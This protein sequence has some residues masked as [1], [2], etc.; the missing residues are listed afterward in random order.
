M[1][2]Y[3]KILSFLLVFA[4]VLLCGCSTLQNEEQTT[5]TPKME[6]VGFVEMNIEPAYLQNAQS[7]CTKDDLLVFM[8]STYT[9]KDGNL[10]IPAGEEEFDD[11]DVNTYIVK[12]DLK[13]NKLVDIFDLKECPIKELWGV[14]LDNDKIVVFSDSEKKNAYYDL[15]M[16]FIEETDRIVFDELE[17]AK[18]SNFYTNMSAARNGFCDF[19]GTNNNQIVYF[20]DDPNTAYIFS[21]DKTYQPSEMSFNNGF[22][23]CETY[24]NSGE[25]ADFKVIDYKGAK[26]INGASIASKDYGYNNITTGQTGIGDK[27]V[28]CTEYLSNYEN[29]NDFV[30]KIFCWNYQN[31]PTNKTLD[32]KSC[33]DFNTFN[34]Q[35]I[36]DIKDEYGVD[37]Y[38]NEPNENIVDNVSCKEE[39]NQVLLYDNLNAIDTFFDSLP[40]GMISEIYSGYKNK[41][42]EMSG[43]RIDLVSEITFDAGA[44]AQNFVD[45]MEVCFPFNGVTM[46]NLSHEFMHLFEARLADYD[47]SYYEKWD[48]FNKGFEREYNPDEETHP[49]YKFDE[50]QFLTDYSATNNVEERAEIFSYLY[51]GGGPALE[52]EVLRKKADYLI[53]II[54]NSFPSVQNA[55]SVCWEN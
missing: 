25:S 41:D 42:A 15:N 52:N 4:I 12:Y 35:K 7:L 19:S 24:G 33:T 50:K 21:T 48:E 3:K 28:V 49:E 20:Y 30:H 32:I 17:E 16:N 36:K 6:P 2:N 29:E 18:K 55:E 44:F 13:N 11:L 23:L 26:E 54:K 31:E 9:D 14:E 46:T 51:T 38:I 40:D 22:V 53:E 47:D 27:Y 43:I 34:T 39:P 45:P 37:V 8:T 1:K 5:K 10:C